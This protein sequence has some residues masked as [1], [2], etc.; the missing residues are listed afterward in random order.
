[1]VANTIHRAPGVALALARPHPN[2][3]SSRRSLAST[4]SRA[5]ITGRSTL[6]SLRSE[7][8]RRPSTSSKTSLIRIPARLSTSGASRRLWAPSGTLVSHFSALPCPRSRKR[9]VWSSIRSRRNSRWGLP[10]YHAQKYGIVRVCNGTGV[11]ER[12]T[13]ASCGHGQQCVC[14][15]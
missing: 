15:K 2:R 9:W 3:I 14:K 11:C 12:Y 10:L 6:S 13:D 7:T 1:M 4:R 5:Q 8:R